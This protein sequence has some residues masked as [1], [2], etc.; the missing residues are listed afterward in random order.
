M[1]KLVSVLLVLVMSIGLGAC[2]KKKKDR[3]RERRHRDRDSVETTMDTHKDPVEDIIVAETERVDVPT[4]AETEIVYTEMVET[5]PAET[6]RAEYVYDNLLG[7]TNWRV[8]RMETA[9]N[10]Y[11][12]NYYDNDTNTV[13]AENFG[14]D[15]NE[16]DATIYDID[17]NGITELI[18]NAVYGGDGA[19]RVIM[20]RNNGGTIERGYID[21]S[22]AAQ[23]LGITIEMVSDYAE[24]FD[25]NTMSVI[26]VDRDGNHY[27][28]PFD[29]FNYSPY[30]PSY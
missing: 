20:F 4:S 30:T 19:V 11:F 17:G 23:E 14:I 16:S 21:E 15:G 25:E 8:E 3:D 9:P 7:Y 10:F 26:L 2:T 6:E 28:V 18:C 27:N 29:W 1:K 12:W 22:R 24:Y 5:E 13:I